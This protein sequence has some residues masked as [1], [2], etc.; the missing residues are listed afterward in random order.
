MSKVRV[1]TISN[2]FF[3]LEGNDIPDP[4][5]LFFDDQYITLTNYEDTEAYIKAYTIDKKIMDT[6][7][8][9]TG[10]NAN[11]FSFKMEVADKLLQNN[12]R[13]LTEE[14]GAG[15][16]V[17]GVGFDPSIHYQTFSTP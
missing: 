2:P 14:F 7:V 16:E 6:A 9:R 15:D 1:L 17:N 3:G 11:L 5:P 8:T 13:I 10:Q 12:D 4:D